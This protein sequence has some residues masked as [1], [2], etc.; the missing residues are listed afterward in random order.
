MIVAIIGVET[1]YGKN[2]GSYRVLDALSTLAFDYPPRSPFFRQELQNFPAAGAR[3]EPGCFDTDRV[4]TPARWATANSCL[5]A[6]ATTPLISMPMVLRI[7]GK[8]PGRHR[9]RGQL[10]QGTRLEEG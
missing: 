2:T 9:Q 6:T 4:P 7:S 5:P 3:T 8:T 1:S 10:F